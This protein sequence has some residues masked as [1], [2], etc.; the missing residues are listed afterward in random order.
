MVKASY[1]RLIRI[2]KVKTSLASAGGKWQN[3]FG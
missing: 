3:L 1:E 2:Q